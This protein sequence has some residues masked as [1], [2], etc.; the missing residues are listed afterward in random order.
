MNLT[1][2]SEHIFACGLEW[3]YGALEIME[4]FFL[5][6]NFFHKRFVNDI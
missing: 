1:H 3:K 5:R 6:K 2:N 4:T